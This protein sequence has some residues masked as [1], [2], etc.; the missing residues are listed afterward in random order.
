MR[1]LIRKEIAFI[2]YF[3]RLKSNEN[4]PRYKDICE[5]SNKRLQLQLGTLR[6]LE[7]QV[8]DKYGKQDL[9][10]NLLKDVIGLNS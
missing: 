8:I 4:N 5:A 1:D 3:N 2:K 6:K 7:D 9:Y 10:K